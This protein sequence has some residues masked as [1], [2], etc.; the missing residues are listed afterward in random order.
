[1]DYFANH[2]FSRGH[3]GLFFR[4]SLRFD[5]TS[6][7]FRLTF[8]YMAG[9]E[10]D[11]EFD[12]MVAKM[13]LEGVGKKI[14]NPF[15]LWTGEFDPLCPLEEAEAFFDEIAGPKE[16]WIM[17]DE[18]HAGFNRGLYNLPSAH[19]AADWLQDK[20]AGKFPKDL[21][22]KILIPLKGAGPYTQ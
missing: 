21:N 22:R 12:K 4:R 19:F 9:I 2:R 6:P 10:D 8:K 18:F 3:A 11:D 5:E 20:L 7:R 16:M 13:T 1:M 17:E 15:L 14:K